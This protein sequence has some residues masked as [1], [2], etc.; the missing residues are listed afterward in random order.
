MNEEEII[1]WEIV[2][3]RTQEQLAMLD[4]TKISEQEKFVREV[5]KDYEYIC[6][7]WSTIKADPV[8]M[9]KQVFDD[10]NNAISQNAKWDIIPDYKT[11]ANL[12]I[13]LLESM[14]VIK[15]N[16][17]EVRINFLSLLFGKKD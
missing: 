15:K 4:E 6:S 17:P 8:S 16:V 9:L 14:W 13:R 3:A 2:D 1:W 11:R 10:S 7:D 12:K 5:L